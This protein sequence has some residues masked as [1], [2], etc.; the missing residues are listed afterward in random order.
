MKRSLPKYLEDI[1]MSILDIESYSAGVQST[2]DI[3]DNKLLFDALCRRFAIIGEAVYQADKLKKNLPIT[4]KEKIKGLRHIIV[5]DYD[6]VRA[7]VIFDIIVN[8]LQ[9]LKKRY[10]YPFGNRDISLIT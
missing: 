5:H 3:E 2:K 10:K 8:K 1:Q 7:S 4:D 9:Q 6:L